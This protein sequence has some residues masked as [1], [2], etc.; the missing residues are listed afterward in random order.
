[1]MDE[2]NEYKNDRREAGYGYEHERR[3]DNFYYWM[4]ETT[5]AIKNIESNYRDHCIRVEKD[6]ETWKKDLEALKDNFETLKNEFTKA[7]VCPY[8]DRI[9]GLESGQVDCE[10]ERQ[11]YRRE[12]KW[13]YGAIGLLYAGTIGAAIGKIWK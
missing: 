7:T 12:R 11:H 6:R 9:I 4:G 8:P 5:T 3:K 2:K 13:L 10:K 1:M